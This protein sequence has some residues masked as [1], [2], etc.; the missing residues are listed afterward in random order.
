MVSYPDA[1]PDVVFVEGGILY[2]DFRRSVAVVSLNNESDILSPVDSG[3]GSLRIFL[4]SSSSLG[5]LVS[6]SL[7]LF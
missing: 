7:P 4:V 2:P 3:T 1:S 6:R 5:M